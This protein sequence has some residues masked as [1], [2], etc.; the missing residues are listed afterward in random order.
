MQL[1]LDEMYSPVIAGMLRRHGVD[2]SSALERGLVGV[3]DEAHLEIAAGESR[4]L[5]T[6]NFSDFIALTHAFLAAGRPHAGVLLV[7]NSFSNCD[8]GRPAETLERF[9]RE[10][11]DGLPP[12]TVMWL[13][14]SP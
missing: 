9:E 2:T 6:N 1:Y 10:H 5:V 14:H 13:P 7:P 12:Y 8:F 3:P 11:P 4:C